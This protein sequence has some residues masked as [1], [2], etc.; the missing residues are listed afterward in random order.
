MEG[1]E[2]VV[3]ESLVWVGC[4]VM[5]GTA[6]AREWGIQVVA[7]MAPVVVALVVEVTKA[8]KV[9]E[10]EQTES[11]VAGCVDLVDPESEGRERA[12]G[13]GRARGCSEKE[14]DERELERVVWA[15]RWVANRAMGMAVAV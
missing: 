4:Q 15:V 10:A 8:A 3:E 6:A 1:V 7:A 2:L 9:S 12:V 11:R 14:V 5:V 13:V